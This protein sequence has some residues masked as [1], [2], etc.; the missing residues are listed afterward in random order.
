MTPESFP[1]PCIPMYPDTSRADRIGDRSLGAALW[2]GLDR[3]V[4]EQGGESVRWIEVF[5]RGAGT[6]HF[7]AG[8]ELKG[9]CLSGAAEAGAGVRKRFCLSDRLAKSKHAR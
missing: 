3:I 6:I 7:C 8:S 5:N 9:A 2:G 1:P 4:F